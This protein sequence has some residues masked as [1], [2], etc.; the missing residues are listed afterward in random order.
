MTTSAREPEPASSVLN[1]ILISADSHI[2]EPPDLW[3]RH[4]PTSLRTEMPK[5]PSQ[6]AGN[7]PGGSDPK[8]RVKEMA[9]DGVSAEFLYP[10]LGL[11]LFAI[12]NQEA[13]EA[14]FRVGNDYMAEYCSAASDRHVERDADAAVRR[15]IWR[16]STPS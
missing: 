6:G 15:N 12:E 5:F 9:V 13:Q 11:R 8:D 1:E 2:I 4:L 14:A 7:K 16:R 3:E 10:T